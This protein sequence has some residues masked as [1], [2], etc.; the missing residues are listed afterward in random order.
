M[1]KIA[2][3]LAVG[4]FALSVVAAGDWLTDYNQ[5]LAKAKAEK[6]LVLLDFTGSDWCP[7]C[8]NLHKN[9]L[10]TRE[11]LDYAAKNLVLVEVDFPRQKQLPAEQRKANQALAERFN[12]RA[13]PTIV[14]LNAEGRELG[15]TQGY[16]GESAKAFI[17]RLENWAKSR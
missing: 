9:V 7:P 5:A 13:Y 15:R 10:S 3:G 12:I 11:F 16:S 4:W 6:K 1:K 17:S 2:L 8:K 14:L